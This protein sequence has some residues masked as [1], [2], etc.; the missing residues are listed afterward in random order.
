MPK[1]YHSF[2]LNDENALIQEMKNIYFSGFQ[3]YARDMWVYGRYSKNLM[4]KETNHEG[5]KMVS[6]ISL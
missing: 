5:H 2:R 4:V 1:S 6:S 3:L